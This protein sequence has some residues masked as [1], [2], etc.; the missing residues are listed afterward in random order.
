[1]INTTAISAGSVATW[2][3]NRVCSRLAGPR[4]ATFSLA[5]QAHGEH[6]V[7]S[8]RHEAAPSVIVTAT[9]AVPT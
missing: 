2:N 4:A 5:S 9:L 6:K 8:H 1:M 3:M 7:R